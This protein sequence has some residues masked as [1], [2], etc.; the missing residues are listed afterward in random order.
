LPAR[1]GQVPNPVHDALGEGLDLPSRDRHSGAL[2]RLKQPTPELVSQAGHLGRL[3]QQLRALREEVT[4][5]SRPPA[6]RDARQRQRQLHLLIP[7]KEVAA[8]DSQGYTRSTLHWISSV[9]LASICI[10]HSP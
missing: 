2:T 1:F 6:R 9:S 3:P 5:A 7:S 8:G 4:G 10:T